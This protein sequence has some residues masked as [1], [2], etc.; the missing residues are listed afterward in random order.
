MKRCQDM[1][2]S[3]RAMQT[4]TGGNLSTLGKLAFSV[5]QP[6]HPLNADEFDR[7]A[8]N[9]FGAMM[10]QADAAIL[11]RL[12]FEGHTL[13]LGQLR[14]LVSDPNASASRK[15]PA[16]EREHRMGELKRRLAG[17]VVERQMEPSHELLEA[18]M[19]QKES[20]QL[21]YI[22]LER[23]TSREWE[24]TMGKNRKQISLDS[25]K[26][27]V[28][29]R[30]DIPDQFYSSELQA[31]EAL[32]R[33]GVAM[34]FADI[35]SWEVHEKYLQQLT[36]HLRVDAPT[37]YLRPSLPQLLKADRQVFLY[38]IRVGVELKRL[39][40]N[41][42]DMDQKIMD[43]LHSYEV[44]FHL[45]PLPKAA[46]KTEPQP[47]NAAP[48]GQGDGKG[49]WK[50][51]QNNRSHPYKPKGGYGGGK[52]KQKGGKGGNL[53][54]RFLL[55][56]DNVSTDTHGRRLCFN[57]QTGKCSEAPDGGEC[58][59]GWHLCARKGCHAPHAEKD[60]NEKK[61]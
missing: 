34:A 21:C 55:G 57:Y 56:R 8:Q 49:S 59:R 32:R 18:M 47:T 14:E 28:K 27:V 50:S 20:N 53:L 15:L 17:V 35:L 36:S 29:E 61:K 31:F 42:L 44:G 24:I 33:R 45:L 5:G 51:W 30:S 1:G 48:Q 37:G 9:L 6:G 13:V 52:G 38:L 43:A 3:A 4:L 39:P 10:V 41:L 54:P 19:Q 26:L 40:N 12:I 7:F 60:H 23:C 58:P 46:P 25:E 16:V 11:K 22:S 2:M